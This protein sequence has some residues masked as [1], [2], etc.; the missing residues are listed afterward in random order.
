[1][2]NQNLQKVQKAKEGAM[3]CHVDVVVETGAM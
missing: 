1:M 2:G 3:T